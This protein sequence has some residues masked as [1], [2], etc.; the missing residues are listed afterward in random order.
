[1]DD[2]VFMDQVKRSERGL[3]ESF[4][5]AM[6]GGVPVPPGVGEEESCEGGGLRMRL[7]EELRIR[8]NVCLPVL[9]DPGEELFSSL[10][11]EEERTPPDNFSDLS[12]VLLSIDLGEGWEGGGRQRG[13]RKERQ[14]KSRQRWREET[15]RGTR[16]G[17]GHKG[18][19]DKRSRRCESSKSRPK[20]RRRRE[21]QKND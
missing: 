17:G 1:M 8:L 13:G 7:T 21:E 14:I 12:T 2:V 16:E 18:G 15:G 19:Q 6:A 20:R 3:A 10:L 9:P 4:W 5:L 11:D